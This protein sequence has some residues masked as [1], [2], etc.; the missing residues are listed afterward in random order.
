[1][2]PATDCRDTRGR[3]G[4]ASVLPVLPENAL[5]PSG[6]SSRSGSSASKVRTP[7]TAPVKPPW[8]GARDAAWAMGAGRNPVRG[9]GPPATPGTP[10]QQP[11]TVAPG[12]LVGIHV[13]AGP[14]RNVGHAT[15]AQAGGAL[16]ESRCTDGGR[17]LVPNRYARQAPPQ[18]PALPGAAR[19]GGTTGCRRQRTERAPRTRAPRGGARLS[20][21]NGLSVVMRA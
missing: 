8:R 4:A 3:P 10:A 18:I 15:H 16:F 17:A 20:G 21:P 19:V 11:P 5:P 2:A 12:S 13:L 6:L 1:M 7:P 9:C 14:C